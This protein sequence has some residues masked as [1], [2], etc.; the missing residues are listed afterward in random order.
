[1]ADA[2]ALHRLRRRIEHWL[3]DRGIEQ[4]GHGYLPLEE[5]TDQIRAGEWYAVRDPAL[6]IV[7]AARLLRTDPQVWGEDDTPAVYVHGLMVERAASGRAWG[8]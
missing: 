7:A 1:M 6:G 8:R 2:K 4:W 5:I 3:A